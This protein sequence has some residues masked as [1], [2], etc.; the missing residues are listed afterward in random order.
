MPERRLFSRILFRTEARLSEPGHEIGVQ[1]IDLSLRG[2][3]LRPLRPWTATSGTPCTLRIRLDEMGTLI[4][5]DGQVAHRDGVYV[6][7]RCT[8]IDL[9]SITHLRRLLE[10]N[11][12]DEALLQRELSAFSR[13]DPG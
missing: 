9:D 10:L 5:M 6:G 8:E 1:V 7:F 3:L 4:H 13:L 2:A 12:G 11:L